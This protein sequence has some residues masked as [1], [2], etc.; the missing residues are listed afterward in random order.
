MEKVNAMK[1]IWT[2]SE[3]Q[4]ALEKSMHCMHS[5]QKYLICNY[6]AVP[7]VWERIRKMNAQS[8]QADCVIP[9]KL[10]KVWYYKPAIELM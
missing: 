9:G 8:S 7:F 3:C 4:A 6:D 5:D 1:K 10:A 2:D